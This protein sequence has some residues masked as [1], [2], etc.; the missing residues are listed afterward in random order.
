MEDHFLT[1]SGPSE[2]E[3]KDRGSRFIAHAIPVIDEQDIREHLD[4]LRGEHPKARHV[5]HASVMGTD[6]SEHRA[7]DDGEPAGSAGPPILN[8]IR[9]KGVTQV[10]VAVVR[11]F[12]GTKL[13]VPGLIHAYKAS[14]KAA[15]DAATVVERVRM[16]RIGLVFPHTAIGEVERIIRQQHL[17]VVE[18]GFAMDCRWAVEMPVAQVDTV[19]AMFAAV[20]DVA[21]SH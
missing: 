10:L 13:G 19:R 2:A 16:G 14:A 3:F 6:G 18:Q 21:V 20:K 4:R 1:I 15:L 9:S 5:C 7:N 11:Y 12:G 8:Q 17:M